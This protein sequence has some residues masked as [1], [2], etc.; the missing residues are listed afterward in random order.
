MSAIR[1][2]LAR[3]RS[4]RA[5]WWGALALIALAAGSTW[6]AVRQAGA[7]PIGSGEVANL[8]TAGPGHTPVLVPA[9][10]LAIA[11]ACAH[12][13]RRDALP[14]LFLALPRRDRVFLAKVVGT[15]LAAALVAVLAVGADLATARA[16]FGPTFPDL[17]AID[18]PAP[19]ILVG[20]VGY[21]VL[22]AVLGLGVG[23]LSRGAPLIAV[24]VAALP[25]GAERLIAAAIRAGVP[26]AQRDL[27]RYLP[28]RAADRML[29]VGEGG[30]AWSPLVDGAALAGLTG[31]VAVLAMV[32]FRRRRA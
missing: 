5:T 3:A 15:A 14:T 6:V 21:V 23:V 10:M 19:R 13:Q 30:G 24:A 9:I 17:A 7:A 20:F 16:V 11:L 29:V 28:F 26:P 18:P 12:E 4:L 1:Y 8:L 2:E 32:T 31:V 27:V 22:A 25:A